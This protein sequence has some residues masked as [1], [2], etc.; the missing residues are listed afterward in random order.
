MKKNV[1]ALAGA[2]LLVLLLVATAMAAG[3]RSGAG[4]GAAG[5]D[6]AGDAI[7]TILGLTHDEVMA[8]RH[9]GL[10][11]AQI[12]ERQQVDPQLLVN[13][14]AARWTERIEARVEAG[15]L[16]PEQATELKAQVETQ[17]KHMVYRTT[18]GGMHGGAVGAGPGMRHGDGNG[19][20]PGAA[21][22]TEPMHG[23]GAMNGGGRM[24]G[25]GAGNRMGPGHHGGG[26]GPGSGN[27]TGP[28]GNGGS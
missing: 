15:A 27:G 17:A 4:P 26:F 24:H 1:V 14:L 18:M 13:E 28:N 16:S 10:S 7:P 25:A 6:G 11:L 9:E 22:C 21:G 12:A 8:L 20:G 2:A 19:T 23:A 5:A 3:P